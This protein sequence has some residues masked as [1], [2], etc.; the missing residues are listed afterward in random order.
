MLCQVIRVCPLGRLSLCL[1]LYLY[2]FLHRSG[3]CSVAAGYVGDLSKWPKRHFTIC[4]I[5]K[6]FGDTL[7]TI[8]SYFF[9]QILIE[10]LQVQILGCKFK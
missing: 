6:T 1:H 5:D 3:N 9:R 4:T 2:L 7:Y 10:C 8:Q